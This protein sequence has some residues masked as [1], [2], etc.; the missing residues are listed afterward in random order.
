[1]DQNH[2]LWFSAF[3]GRKALS[4]VVTGGTAKRFT[5]GG[6]YGSIQQVLWPFDHCCLKYLGM[7]VADPFVAYAVPRVDDAQRAQYFEDWGN[8]LRM[9]LRNHKTMV[10]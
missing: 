4:C 2:A 6:T 7:E 8:H 3:H 9:A 1:M 10:A 5:E